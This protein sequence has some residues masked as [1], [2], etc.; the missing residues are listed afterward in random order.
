M[1]AAADQAAG[2]N[3]TGGAGF[4]TDLEVAEPDLEFYSK[5]AQRPFGGENTATALSVIDCVLP[6]SSQ[7]VGDGD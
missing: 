3:E 7:G 4:V 6:A 2:E 1:E 5:V